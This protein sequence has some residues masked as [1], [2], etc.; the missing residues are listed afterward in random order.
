MQVQNQSSL[1]LS[2][3]YLKILT[4]SYYWNKLNRMQESK[5]AKQQLSKVVLIKLEI[6]KSKS[7]FLDLKGEMIS[8]KRL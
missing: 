3:K 4:Q 5:K 1:N 7:I 8:E 6:T 2:A